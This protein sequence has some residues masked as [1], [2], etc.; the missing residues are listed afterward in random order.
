VDAV[1]IAAGAGDRRAANT[2][3]LG[4]L[5]A[6]LP[7][8]EG[9]WLSVIERLVKAKALESNRNAFTEGRRIAETA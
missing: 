7:V 9:E 1:D 8:S 5:S 6:S 2:V 4:V 3:L